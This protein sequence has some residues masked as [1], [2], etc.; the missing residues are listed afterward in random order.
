M[1]MLEFNDECIEAGRLT[2]TEDLELADDAEE[3]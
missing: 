1:E 2:P 3:M